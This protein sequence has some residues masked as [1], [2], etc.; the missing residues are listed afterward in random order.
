VRFGA[1]ATLQGVTDRESHES[2]TAIFEEFS[3]R[4]F[5]YVRRR[6]DLAT[7]QDVVADVFVV[8]WQ[9]R[10]DLPDELLPWL[11][12]VARNTLAN[13]H[14]RE[15]HQAKLADTVARLERT[16]GPAVGA[17]ESVVDR[18]TF[19]TALA[20]L[21]DTEREAL[22]LVAWDGLSRA[23]ASTVAGCSQRA[24]EVRLSRARARLTRAV[25][26]QAEFPETPIREA[27]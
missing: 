7:A 8:A 2:F 11:L 16:A 21:G 9:R 6:C 25:A 14:R 12:V 23:A 24:F 5:N 17:D 22:L 3:P 10:A 18:H 13:R 19:L 15:L 4:V 1:R 26:Q 20:T 27:R